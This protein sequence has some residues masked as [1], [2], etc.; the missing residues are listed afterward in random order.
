MTDDEARADPR[1][2][3]LLRDYQNIWGEEFA[4]A[5]AESHAIRHLVEGK[6]VATCFRTEG[7]GVRWLL[8]AGKPPQRI[9]HT[10]EPVKKK[11][12]VASESD[13]SAQDRQEP[14]QATQGSEQRSMFA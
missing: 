1:F 7:D 3:E 11:R 4:P 2:P 12:H 5:F 9:E 13:G 6:P 8:V 14:G 10:K